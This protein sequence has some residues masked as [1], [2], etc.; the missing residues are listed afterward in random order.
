MLG[1]GKHQPETGP[2]GQNGVGC[3]GPLK[4]SILY[5]RGALG[6]LVMQKKT[7]QTWASGRPVVQQSWGQEGET[8]R[9][10]KELED[11]QKSQGQA[12]LPGLLTWDTGTAVHEQRVS[13]SNIH[14]SK[15][16]SIQLLGTRKV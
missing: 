16:D 11:K 15:P 3:S 2:E 13:G 4:D 9:Q 14:E 6:A 12:C 1:T 8:W 7:P 10:G 5:E